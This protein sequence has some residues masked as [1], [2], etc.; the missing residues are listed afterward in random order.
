MCMSENRALGGVAMCVCVCM[1]TCTLSWNKFLLSMYHVEE[2]EMAI[3]SSILAWKI[4]WTVE[5]DGLYGP[6]GFK[7]LDMTEHA[8]MHYVDSS[9]LGTI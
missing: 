5:P 1:H 7:E 6:W 3:H 9:M 2:E 8:R 4:P